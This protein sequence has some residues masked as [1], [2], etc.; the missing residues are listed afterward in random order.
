MTRPVGETEVVRE[1]EQATVAHLVAYEAPGDGA[2][3][4]PAVGQPRS[5]RPPHRRVQ[6]REVEAHVVSHDHASPHEFE[7]RRQ[8]FVDGRCREHHGLGDA[9]EHRDGGRD[10]CARVD[11][12]LEGA[13]ALASAHLDRS[14]LGDRA[15]LRRGA[16]GLEVDDAEGDL[17]ERGAEVVE[18]PLHGLSE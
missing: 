14:H 9:G 1:R 12:C 2:R 10:L 15:Q 13:E 8:D 4:G 11:E 7:E 6:E 16:G 18:R 17:G 3:V 5:L